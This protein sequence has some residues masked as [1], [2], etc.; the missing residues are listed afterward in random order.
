MVPSSPVVVVW[1]VGFRVLGWGGAGLRGLGIGVLGFG[2]QSYQVSL[3]FSRALN[4]G[5]F[6]VVL[7]PRCFIFLPYDAGVLLFLRCYVTGAKHNTWI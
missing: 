2:A 1:F 5:F 7:K 3:G 4:L 6:V